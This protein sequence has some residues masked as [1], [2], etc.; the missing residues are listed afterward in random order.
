MSSISFL[1]GMNDPKKLMKEGDAAYN[2]EDYA[3]A[4]EKYDRLIDKNPIYEK[5]DKAKLMLALS[6]AAAENYKKSSTELKKLS[7]DPL[8][9]DKAKIDPLIDYSH[10]S[11]E[12]L[13]VWF[14]CDLGEY[15]HIWVKGLCWSQCQATSCD[16]KEC[17]DKKPS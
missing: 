5:R 15:G 2:K 14:C 12:N 10:T 4:I 9:K 11:D 17:K 3:E 13:K 6:Y 1:T 7:E 8:C 16:E